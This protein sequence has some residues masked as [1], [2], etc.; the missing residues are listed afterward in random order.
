M[1]PIPGFLDEMPLARAAWA[2]ADE[3][4]RGQTRKFDGAPF[5]THTAE[6]AH[7]L[8]DEG[9]ADR[10]VAAGV[11]HDTVERT[12]A[13]LDDL[14]RRFGREVADLVGAVTEDPALG[15]YRARKAALRRQATSSGEEA[16][17]L[18]AADKVS[19]VRQYEA[20]LESTME[21][22]DPP[23][24][25]RLHHYEQSLRRLERV[26]PAHPLVRRLRA[27]LAKVLALAAD[28]ASR[29]AAAEGRPAPRARSAAGR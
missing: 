9:A 23:R 3:H 25:R 8:Y 27:E 5:M 12:D 20:Q 2:Y 6:V 22:A 16:A 17:I 26:L 24:A 13:T 28:V 14:H 15:S 10:L 7:L 4:H 29:R 1:A 19:K 18:F 11:L 21:G